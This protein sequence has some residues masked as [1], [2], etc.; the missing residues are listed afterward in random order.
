VEEENVRPRRVLNEVESGKINESDA[1]LLL[2][3]D[4][5]FK[6]LTRIPLV[7]L[8]KRRGFQE[9]LRPK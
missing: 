4:I 8:K 9:Y 3:K 6:L 1:I 7:S 2:L 5:K